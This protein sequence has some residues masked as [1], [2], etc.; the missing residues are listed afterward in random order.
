MKRYLGIKSIYLKLIF[1]FL[2]ML[3]LSCMIAF[4][5]IFATRWNALKKNINTEILA[6]AE[7]FQSFHKSYQADIYDIQR[8]LKDN[9]II[10]DIFSSY[11]DMQNNSD[12]NNAISKEQYAEMLSGK[13]VKLE[14]LKKRRFMPAVGISAGGKAII[15]HPRLNLIENFKSTAYVLL[16]C[17]CLDSVLIALA[18]RMLVKPIK[19]LTSAAKEVSS[20]NFNIR[21]ETRSSDE[22]GQLA[23]NFNIMATELKNMEYLRKNFISNVSHEFKTPI[24]S[25]LGFIK[26][27]RDRRLSQE[28]FNEYTNIIILETERLSNLSS[29]LLRLAT[30]ENQAIVAKSSVFFLDEQ[31][32]RVIVLLENKWSFKGI[33][34]DL[35]MEELEYSGDEELLQQVWINLITNAIKFSRDGGTIKILL[36]K[37]EDIIKFQIIDNGIGIAQEDKTRIFD[38]FYKG[39]KS[40]SNDGS[41]LGLAIS[42]KIVELHNGR[43]YFESE[44]GSGTNFTVELV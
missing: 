13:T 24:T 32:R 41:G 21:V 17:L 6:K 3:F 8:L 10:I 4:T 5:I 19:K 31:I 15:I 33:N 43:I 42:K 39:D 27:I 35:Q 28:D 25:I 16:I 37:L 2:G 36:N 23:E 44:Y 12:Y 20:G 14:K 38:M 18:A 9:Y 34:L 40:R 11:E 30:V 26:L 22:I 7:N 1:V 29:N